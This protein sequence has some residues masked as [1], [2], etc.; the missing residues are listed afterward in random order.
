MKKTLLI[1]LLALLFQL[2][3]SNAYAYIDPGS[4]SIVLQV[5]IAGFL[6]IVFSLK[7]FFKRFLPWKNRNNFAE[8]NSSNESEIT[9]EMK[10][11]GTETDETPKK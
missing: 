9:L 11:T 6:G 5:I 2:K 8:T 3:T 10:N 7:T 4:G 1:L